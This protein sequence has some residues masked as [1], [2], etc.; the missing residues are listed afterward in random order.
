MLGLSPALWAAGM[1]AASAGAAPRHIQVYAEQGRF[2]GWPAN[3]GIWSWGREIACGFAAA[4]FIKTDPERHQRDRSRPDVPAIARSLNTGETW[5]IEFPNS[6]LMPA[7]SGR[8]AAPLSE[9]MDFTAPG[10]ALT[11]RADNAHNSA[12][13]FWHS[14][15]RARTWSGP[16]QFPLFGRKGI[17]ARTDYLVL[18]PREALVFITSA[19][20]N[21][22]EGRPLCVRTA[23]GGLTWNIQGWIGDEPP[24]F[25]IMPSTVRLPSGRILCAVRVKKDDQT[26]WIDLYASDD[27]GKSWRAFARPVPFSGGKSGNPPSLKRLPDGRLTVTWG[28]RGEPYSIRA[29]HSD[30]DGRTWSDAV[31][32]RADGGA[33]DLGYTRDAIRPDGKLVT[34]YYWSPALYAEREIVATIWDPGKRGT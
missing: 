20:E 7:Q 21:G 1:S 32:L 5:Q 4:Y 9:P 19:K 3:H 14:T 6:L 12:S 27:L 26:D 33:W 23:D 11:L 34:L 8:A 31:V 22:R 25:A 29:T 28:Y 24:G 2:G 17:A 15:D 13:L 30:D 18:G 10:F 16:F